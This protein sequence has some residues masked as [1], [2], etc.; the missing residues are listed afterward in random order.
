MKVISSGQA[1]GATIEGLDLSQPLSTDDL[2]AVLHVLGERGVVRF[3]RQTL[4]A[5]QLADFSAHFGRLETNVAS[6]HYQEPGVPEV[7]TLSNIVKEGKPIGLSDAG[8][9][10]HTD[11]SYNRMIAFANVLYGVRIPHRDGKPLGATEFSN[12]HA[13]YEDLP[14]D[15]K[16]KL[17]PMTVTH[18]FNKF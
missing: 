12:M 3:P 13:A 9:S 7:M 15:L 5:R 8:Q 17:E 18:H 16:R 10:W 11:M 1:L 4:T 14:A 6:T 2:A